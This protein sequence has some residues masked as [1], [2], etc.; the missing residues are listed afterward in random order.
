MKILF[1]KYAWEDYLFFQQNNKDIFNRINLIIKDI[2]R[3]PFDE[4]GKL[5]LLKHSLAGFWSRRINQKYRLVY[6]IENNV[7]YIVQCRYHYQK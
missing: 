6:T 1:Y 5:E 4:I 7:I 2:S 3:S